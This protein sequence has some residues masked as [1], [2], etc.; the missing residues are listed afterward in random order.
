MD[1]RGGGV[2][3]III[4]KSLQFLRVTSRGQPGT[5]CGTFSSAWDYFLDARKTIVPN[6]GDTSGDSGR[7]AWM[8]TPRGIVIDEQSSGSRNAQFACGS[9]LIVLPEE[10]SWNAARKC[11]FAYHIYAPHTYIFI[12]RP[13]VFSSPLEASTLLF[14]ASTY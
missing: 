3:G 6:C 8:G 5:H 7:G 13:S 4:V 12:P 14:T 2:F 1:S 10:R 9:G 11:L